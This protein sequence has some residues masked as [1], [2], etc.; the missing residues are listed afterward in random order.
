MAQADAKMRKNLIILL[1]NIDTVLLQRVSDFTQGLLAASNSDK[2]DWWDDL[3][4]SVKESYE[5]GMKDI[6]EGNMI[7][8]EEMLKQYK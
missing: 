1:K 2:T 3:P 6:E 7:T 8:L 4:E 5:R